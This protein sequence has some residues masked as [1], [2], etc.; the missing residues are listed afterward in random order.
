MIDRVAEVPR[1]AHPSYA[2]GFYDRDNEA[3]KR[4]DEI[5]RDPE[6]FQEWLRDEV[7]V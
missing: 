2:Q 7:L 5:S 1:G 6:A 4:W 3:Y